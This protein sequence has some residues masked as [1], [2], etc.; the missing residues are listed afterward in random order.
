M[1]PLHF[2]VLSGNNKIVTKLLI[3]GVNHH[4]INTIFKLSLNLA[5]EN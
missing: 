5:Q 4:S 2:A 3:S 1:T